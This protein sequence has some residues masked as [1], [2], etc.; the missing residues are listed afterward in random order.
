MK[1]LSLL[2]LA[3]AIF[4][5]SCQQAPRPI[6][7][8]EVPM[9]VTKEVTIKPK[10]KKS[11]ARTRQVT[12]IALV[13]ISGPEAKEW[14]PFDRADAVMKYNKMPL[15]DKEILFETIASVYGKLPSQMT[16]SSKDINTGIWKAV[17]DKGVDLNFGDTPGDWNP[18]VMYVHPVV[19][20]EMTQFFIAARENSI[21]NAELELWQKAGCNI[22]NTV[23]DSIT[24]AAMLSRR[25]EL[26]KAGI[27][28]SETESG[29]RAHTVKVDW[30]KYR[31]ET[32]L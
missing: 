23:P 9:F 2:L 29:F 19:I 8:A 16:Y 3:S 4:C 24:M 6:I 5:S 15:K 11:A 20:A 22:I 14:D 31:A 27:I 12:E 30:K 17:S 25:N 1:K 21:S 18:Y 10:R 7:Q 13:P 26:A 28:I 32:A